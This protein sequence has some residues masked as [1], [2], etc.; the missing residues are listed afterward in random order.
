MAQYWEDWSGSTIGQAPT[1]WTSRWGTGATPSVVSDALGPAGRAL[2]IDLASPARRALSFDA[3]GSVTDFKIRALIK[4]PTTTTAIANFVGVAGRGS[5]AAGSETA[6]VNLFKQTGTTAAS[7]LIAGTQYG[8]AGASLGTGYLYTVGELYWIGLEV[9]GTSVRL[10]A[11]AAATPGTLLYDET[12]TDTAV[13]ASGW[14]GLFTLASSVAPYYVYAVGVGT[15]GDA[16]PTSNPADTQAPTLTSPTGTATGATSASGTVSTNEGNGT[17][18]WLASTSA[19]ATAAA[20]KAG[21]SQAVS[22]TGSQSVTVSGL[23]ASTAYYMHYLHRDTAGNDSAVST[24][25]S[26]TT[27]AVA[28]KGAV[29]TLYSGTTAQASV[30]GITAR[31]W[32]SPTAAGAPLAKTD[33]ASTDATG[34]LT[35]NID[36]ATA[37]AVGGVGYLSLYKAGA[38]AQSDLHFA[39]R[40]TVSDIG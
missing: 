18:Y 33:T 8:G 17:L 10:T 4:A 6:Y 37:L 27:N 26:F 12:V 22:A 40:I 23:T 5:G 31:W 21:S 28:V 14:L 38:D 13:S 19:T 11:A 7:R 25:A 2:K 29:I 32:D 34:K 3:A 39:S 30:T 36:S 24:S 16:A 1:G 20:V 15:G 9:T 35:L